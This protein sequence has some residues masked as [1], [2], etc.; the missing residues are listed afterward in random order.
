MR[1]DCQIPGKRECGL[2]RFDSKEAVRNEV[3]S[4]FWT[5]GQWELLSYQMLSVWENGFWHKQ[6][7]GTVAKAGLGDVVEEPVFIAAMFK[8][9]IRCPNG[10]AKIHLNIE[11]RGWRHCSAVHSLSSVHKAW[12]LRLTSALPSESP[13]FLF[14]PRPV[15]TIVRLTPAALSYAGTHAER[16]LDWAKVVTNLR[17]YDPERWG[18]VKGDIWQWTAVSQHNWRRGG[19]MRRKQRKTVM[20]ATIGLDYRIPGIQ[21]TGWK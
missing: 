4:Q 7:E 2:E 17:D 6:V 21:K 8:M 16:E 15:S 10:L 9:F 3:L 13:G 1:K 19:G 20:W 11:V 18:G 14:K 12:H 5:Q